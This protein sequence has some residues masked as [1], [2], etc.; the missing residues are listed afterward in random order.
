MVDYRNIILFILLL[1][2]CYSEAENKG[3]RQLYY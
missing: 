1:T 3:D 2:R